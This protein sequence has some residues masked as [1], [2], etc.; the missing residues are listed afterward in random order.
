MK[1]SF[2][3]IDEFPEIIEGTLSYKQITPE[4]F[5]QTCVILRI[6]LNYE[7]EWKWIAKL[8]LWLPLPPTWTSIMENTYEDI[9]INVSMNLDDSMDTRRDK[10]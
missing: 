6:D 4:Q 9:D 10:L 3:T 2:G 1:K 8:A 5:A 7:Y